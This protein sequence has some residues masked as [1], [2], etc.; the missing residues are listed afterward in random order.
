MYCTGW[1]DGIWLHI[2]VAELLDLC[3]GIGDWSLDSVVFWNLEG[4]YPENRCIRWIWIGYGMD[5][6]YLS[7]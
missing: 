2:P 4:I 7:G 1:E 5:L 6:P 3:M